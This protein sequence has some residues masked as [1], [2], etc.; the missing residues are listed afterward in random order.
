MTQETKSNFSAHLSTSQCCCSRPTSHHWRSLY[1][2]RRYHRQ[3]SPQ[4]SCKDWRWRPR[5]RFQPTTTRRW[6]QSKA[7]KPWYMSDWQCLRQSD[8]N[9]HWLWA[10][11]VWLKHIETITQSLL[12]TLTSYV[13]LTKNHTGPYLPLKIE[14][15]VVKT[16][17][18]LSK[19]WCDVIY[20]CISNGIHKRFVPDH[21]R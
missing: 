5:L 4:P 11:A 2:C 20:V 18:K 9:C 1:T 21:L 19:H 12:G 10:S 16:W 14:T 17:Y 3:S 15:V 6:R 8:L 13:I 7:K